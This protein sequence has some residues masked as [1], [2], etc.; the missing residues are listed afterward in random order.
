MDELLVV[1]QDAPG[2]AVLEGD[3]TIGREG[4]DVLL[5]DPEVSRHHAT[6][7]Q[8]AAGTAVEDL[9]S[10]NGTFVNDRRI[11]GLTKLRE[12]DVVRVGGARWRLERRREPV[13]GV[14]APTIPP[15]DGA[16]GGV[17]APAPPGASGGGAPAPSGGSR[18]DVPAP[19]VAP[20]AIRRIVAASASAPTDPPVFGAEPE[21]RGG[22]SAA[23]RLEATLVSYAVVLL[24]AVAVVV[25]LAQR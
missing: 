18:G 20:S 5:D 14:S 4:C 16:A 22:G 11:S 24:T 21:R 23:R 2:P 3:V 7:R 1:A 25:Y 9:G 19:E 12:G 13:P 15:G 17:A 6:I 10:R 8:S